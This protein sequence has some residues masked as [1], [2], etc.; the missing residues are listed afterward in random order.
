MITGENGMTYNDMVR[1]VIGSIY[2]NKTS[3]KN[4]VVNSQQLKNQIEFEKEQVDIMSLYF[5]FGVQNYLAD[6]L[7]YLDYITYIPFGKRGYKF[8]ED[9]LSKEEIDAS[10]AELKKNTIHK[11]LDKIGIKINPDLQNSIDKYCELSYSTEQNFSN[12]ESVA[13]TVRIVGGELDNLISN[14][15]LNAEDRNDKMKKILEDIMMD[16]KLLKNKKLNIEK[17][18]PKYKNK[19]LNNTEIEYFQ[20]MT[21][22][23]TKTESKLEDKEVA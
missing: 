6:L 19:K 4:D 22:F 9:C 11:M 13:A 7:F 10:V 21:G 15:Q 1:T 12:I 3:K 5:N 8:L 14:G 20:Q 18:L 17:Y 23:P 16:T 2:Y